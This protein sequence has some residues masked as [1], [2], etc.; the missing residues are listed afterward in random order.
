MSSLTIPKIFF[1]SLF[2]LAFM[3]VIIAIHYLWGK[4]PPPP[5][6]SKFFTKHK[7]RITKIVDVGIICF[8]LIYSSIMLFF[9]IAE[10]FYAVR[11]PESIRATD[12]RF[13]WAAFFLFAIVVS[14]PSGMFIG[15]LSVFQS[16][17]TRI[18]RIILLIICLLPIVFTVLELLI[19]TQDNP[20]IVIL[21]CLQNSLGS[22][23]VNSPAIITGKHFLPVSWNIMRKLRLVS[24]DYPG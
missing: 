2:W 4:T 21:I 14:G 18:K 22:W 15:I 8:V 1:N 23:L 17:I 11:M 9:P 12:L 20:R 5:K 16:N 3:V 24:G 19:S 10:I 7:K 6:P 13:A